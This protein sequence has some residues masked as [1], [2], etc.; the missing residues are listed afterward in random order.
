MFSGK[1]PPYELMGTLGLGESRVQPSPAPCHLG[2]L[3]PGSPTGC[4][5]GTGRKRPPPWARWEED[6][7][8]VSGASGGGG[9]FSRGIPKQPFNLLHGLRLC[10]KFPQLSPT[11]QIWGV[12]S[13][14][15]EASFLPLLG[16]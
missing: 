9:K 13:W 4:L 5:V 2:L 12:L 1:R 3:T 11:G 7:V 16:T 6:V 10:F 15:G 8:G 14:C